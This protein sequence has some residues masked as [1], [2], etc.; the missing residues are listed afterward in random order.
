MANT[1]AIVKSEKQ[2]SFVRSNFASLVSSTGFELAKI[3]SKTE[4]SDVFTKFK[5]CKDLEI[6]FSRAL[7]DNMARNSDG[8]A[9]Q[10]VGQTLFDIMKTKKTT[11]ELSS[12]DKRVIEE[13]NRESIDVNRER[14][15][16]LVREIE[17]ITTQLNELF[18]NIKTIMTTPVPSLEQRKKCKFGKKCRFHKRAPGSCIFGHDTVML[19]TNELPVSDTA[20]ASVQN[21]D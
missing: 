11:P 3:P 19:L 14:C 20:V 16:E 9:F 5:S 2:I 13:Y 10:I 18:V 8:K 6:S 1:D 15:S 21:G 4:F 7:M 17:E 12:G